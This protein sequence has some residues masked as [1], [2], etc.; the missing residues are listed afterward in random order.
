MSIGL[1]VL[2]ADYRIPSPRFEHERGRDGQSYVRRDFHCALIALNLFTTDI[3]YRCSEA[4]IT[5]IPLLGDFLFDA[6]QNSQQWK[7]ELNLG[8][9]P[10]TECMNALIP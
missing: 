1:V 10:V 2:K 7:W 8:G 3:Q 9:I 6:A 4:P 5:Q